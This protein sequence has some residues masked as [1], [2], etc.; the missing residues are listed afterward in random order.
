MT[1]GAI[2]VNKEGK[3]N[4]T[5]NGKI[6]LLYDSVHGSCCCCKPYLLASFT[7]SN[8]T[9]NLTQYQGDNVAPSNRYWRLTNNYTSYVPIKTGCVNKDGK[10]V[11]LPS[12]ISPDSYK[13]TWVFR[14]EIG[15]KDTTGNYINW[16][17]G[18]RSN[19]FSC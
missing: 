14:L 6:D 2:T 4:I 8:S 3:R 12:S 11:G 17:D 10:L 9:W 15:C 13:Y 1:K 18:S 7:T 19:I 5:A 16:A